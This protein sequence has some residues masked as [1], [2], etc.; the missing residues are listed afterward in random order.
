[1]WHVHHAQATEAVLGCWRHQRTKV[2]RVPTL[3]W[4]K[5]Q[6]AIALCFVFIF[7]FLVFST[8]ARVA[9]GT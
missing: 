4:S 2:I 3:M 8:W 1:M 9:W 5:A 7:L 6:D